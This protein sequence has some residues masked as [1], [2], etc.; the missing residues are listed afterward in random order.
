MF[1]FKYVKIL[2]F[3]FCDSYKL[4]QNVKAFCLL[5][6]LSVLVDFNCQAWPDLKQP[7]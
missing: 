1:K 7:L 3:G 6:V 2:C 5:V 4:N